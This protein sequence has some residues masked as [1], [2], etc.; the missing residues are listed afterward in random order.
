VSWLKRNSQVNF[1]DLRLF[2]DK[3]LFRDGLFSMKDKIK[4]VINDD[5]EGADARKK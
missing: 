5:Y 1:S 3:S 2:G 4:G